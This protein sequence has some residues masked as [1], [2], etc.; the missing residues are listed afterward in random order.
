MTGLI[1]M[2]EIRTFAWTS[3]THRTQACRRNA[4]DQIL[5]SLG[6]GELR[7]CF[8]ELQCLSVLNAKYDIKTIDD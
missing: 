3:F 1:M 5:W 2:C 6:N 7:I 4:A 8:S